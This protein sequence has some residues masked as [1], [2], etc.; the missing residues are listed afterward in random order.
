[1]FVCHVPHYSILSA[2]VKL[3]LET[4]LNFVEIVVNG[5]VVRV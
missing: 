4:I 3:R 1:L 5:C 2:F